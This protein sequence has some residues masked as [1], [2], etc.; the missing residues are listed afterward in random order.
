[1]RIGII[2]A[3][4][5]GCVVGGLLARAGRQRIC[6]E[7]DGVEAVLAEEVVS[8]PAGESLPWALGV[9]QRDGMLVPILDLKALGARLLGGK[10]GP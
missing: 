8:V 6:L 10:S 2:G 7:V 4:A 3:G 1:M 9:A 5:I